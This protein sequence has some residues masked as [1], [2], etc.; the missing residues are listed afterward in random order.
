MKFLDKLGFKKEEIDDF[1]KNTPE[2]VIAKI[3]EYQKLVT[4]NIKFL[5][6]LGITNYKEVFLNYYEMFLMDNSNFADIFNQYDRD[7][8]VDKIQKNIKVVEYL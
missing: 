2:L 7:D 4:A 8:L 6:D 3:K 5:K 1:V